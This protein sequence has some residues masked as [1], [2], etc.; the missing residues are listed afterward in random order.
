MPLGVKENVSIMPILYSEEICKDGVPGKWLNEVFPGEAHVVLKVFLEKSIQIPLFWRE[1]L[2]QIIDGVGV[3]YEL[4][5]SRVGTCHK[6]LIWIQVDGVALSLKYVV[7]PFHELY[8]QH[9]LAHIVI[10]LN[11]EGV[12]APTFI[13]HT[14]GGQLFVFS[15]HVLE[16]VGVR[17]T[18]LFKIRVWITDVFPFIQRLIGPK[19]R[20]LRFRL[21]WLRQKIMSRFL[22]VVFRWLIKDIILLFG[23]LTFLFDLM[24]A[25][26]LHYDLER[27]SHLGVEGLV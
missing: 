24:I 27:G 9:L 14:E 1:F 20:I 21:L 25:N 2:L 6:D 15:D 4:E 8:G 18:H 7:Q 12:E 10:G 22:A 13:F 16:L 3:W 23:A 5:Q 19:L 17:V 11:Y 26:C